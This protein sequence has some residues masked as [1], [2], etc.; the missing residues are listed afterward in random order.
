VKPCG[1]PAPGLSHGARLPFWRLLVRCR[2][3]RPSSRRSIRT[4]PAATCAGS[5]RAHRRCGRPVTREELRQAIWGDHTFV[6]F[7]RGLNFC[8]AQIRTAL[9]DERFKTPETW[10]LSQGVCELSANISET[11]AQNSS[12]Q[13]TFRK[14]SYES[15]RFKPSVKT[16][17][18]GIG[19]QIPD[20]QPSSGTA[21]NL[22]I[23]KHFVA[24]RT[25][26][27]RQRPFS[28]PDPVS[29]VVLLNNFSRLRVGAG[30]VTFSSD[31]P[32]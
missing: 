10:G 3:T 27:Q 25:F 31:I 14:I 5:G 19:V 18:H 8:I 29:P 32:I 4:A 16:L 17:D 15:R 21:P 12:D 2:T 7:D 26:R 1:I 9:G 28:Q 13:S 24:A 30:R 23:Y 20:S 6:D 11:P 22:K